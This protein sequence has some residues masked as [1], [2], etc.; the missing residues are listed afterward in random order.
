MNKLLRLKKKKKETQRDPMYAL[1]SPSGD[2]L[3]TTHY[4]TREVD[5]DLIH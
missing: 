4:I 1:V 5:I 3:K 2:F